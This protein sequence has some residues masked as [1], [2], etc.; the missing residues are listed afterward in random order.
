MKYR[1]YAPQAPV[2]LIEGENRNVV[3]EINRLLNSL[4]PGVKAAILGTT[5]NLGAYHHELVL[6]LGSQKEPAQ[7]AARLYDLL[8][9]CDQLPIDRI[10][11]EGIAPQGVG[12]AIAN[13]LHKA[14][15]GNVIHV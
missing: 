4:D 7:I 9:L 5:E 11:I 12:L 15:G 3:A 1:H 8:R 2:W 13:R 6:D 14:A 10:F